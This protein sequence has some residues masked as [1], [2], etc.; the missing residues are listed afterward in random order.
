M[1]T[2]KELAKQNEKVLETLNKIGSVKDVLRDEDRKKLEKLIKNLNTWKE[3]LEDE[4]YT[5]AIIGL[6]KA[7][8]STFANALLK[9][10]FLPEAKDRCTF[11]TAKI[12]SSNEDYAEVKFYSK[13]EFLE[14][15]KGLC[16][17]IGFESDYETASIVDLENF[18][19][20]Q[21]DI[22][23]NSKAV[24]ELTDIINN[25]SAIEKYLTGEKKIFR[26][27]EINEIKDYIVNPIKAR[28]IDN[29][30][31]KST[32]FKGDKDLVI[33]DV[34]GFDSPTKLHLEQA[35]KYTINSD[36]VIML[37]S[38]ADRV[39]FTD[40]QTKFLNETKDEYGQKLSNKMIV[41][42][43][44]F[45]KHDKSDVNEFYDLLV[46]ELKKK[47]LYKK[48]NLFL[49]SPL[50]YLEKNNI[51]STDK[52]KSKLEQLG[53][54][55]GIEEVKNRI[56]E[57]MNGEIL[58][59]INDSFEVDVTEAYQFLAEFKKN[60]NP[61]LN[62]K[63]M[64]EDEVRLIDK[65]WK[66]ISNKLREKLK[67]IYKE[68][69]D[70]NYNLDEKISKQVSEIWINEL[71]EKVESYIE[72]EKKN[73]VDGR[74]SIEQPEKI[75]DRVREKIYKESLEKIVEV[76]TSVINEKN[77][78]E[79]SKLFDTIKKTIYENDFS[80][81]DELKDIINKIIE[82]FS[83]DAKSYKPLILRFLNS[84]F[85]ILILN[86]ISNS[87]DGE[88]VR[89]FKILRAD[90]ESLMQY[91]E[92]YN[93]EYS[94]FKQ[95]F[96]QM[97][98]IQN[99]GFKNDKNLGLSQLLQKAKVASSYQDV[100]EE[101]IKDLKNLEIIFNTIILK[102]IKIENPFKDSLKDQ[103]Q[104][105]LSDLDEID[106]SEIRR[107]IIR[108]IEDIAK[109]EY[110]RLNRD[111]KTMKTIEFITNEIENLKD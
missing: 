12:E 67:I 86:K 34:P 13:N 27:N 74:I 104:A 17:E 63:K 2:K 45:D 7:G 37:V 43:T 5:I 58:K 68:I 83:Y 24:E 87:E 1:K 28:A 59:L 64:R 6:E 57:M 97:L 15:Y 99:I 39:S 70:E 18:L 19:E 48:E 76:S 84:V 31:I 102:A 109:I 92:N 33:Y 25:K 62:E 69:N 73:I 30:V 111:E 55:D 49:A 42:A 65:K 9:Q 106:D 47:D 26:G 56:K 40:T 72:D 100:Q 79:Y 8:K 98:L 22:I 108:N 60:Y 101:I 44:K 77:Q 41:V 10:N 46:K 82:K 11:T 38:I 88:R 23:K 85:E 35:K 51:V 93:D 21:P 81:A 66:N 36:I 90:I 50:G 52:A 14:K 75:N 78:I 61:A 4:R 53:M 54:S 3:K 29:I 89:R 105:I 110:S 71:I 107:F 103:I 95:D 96:I 91:D 80:D 32:Q 16:K 94:T 20:T